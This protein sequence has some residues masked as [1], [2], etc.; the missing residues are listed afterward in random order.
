MHLLCFALFSVAV[1]AG[2]FFG[3]LRPRYNQFIERQSK[4]IQSQLEDFVREQQNSLQDP[5][6]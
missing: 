5:I 4:L 3:I 2:S 1:A 6:Q